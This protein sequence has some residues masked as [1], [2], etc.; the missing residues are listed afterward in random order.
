MATAVNSVSGSRARSFISR[1]R[2][3]DQ[4]AWLITL[5]FAATII[6]TTVLLAVQ[7]WT[8]SHASRVKFG[9][10]FLTSS[11]WDPVNDQ[12]GAMPFIYGTIVTSVLALL[13]S[14]PLG[15]GAA[16]FL[17]ELAPPRLSNLFTFLVELLAA[18]PSVIFGLLAIFALVPPM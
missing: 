13:I 14:V 9:A 5:I 15:V 11:T 12:F 10:G 18:V 8:H 17:S 4:I 1:V 16:I 3:G 6:G 7:L 2:A